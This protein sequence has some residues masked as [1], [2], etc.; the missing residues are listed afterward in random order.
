MPPSPVGLVRA[1][2]GDADGST[3]FVARGLAR[4]EVAAIV[5]RCEAELDVRVPNALIEVLHS[6]DDLLAVLDTLLSHRQ[7]AERVQPESA[8]AAVSSARGR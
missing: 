5:L 6:P 8:P 7:S 2:V 4:E 3:S 1:H